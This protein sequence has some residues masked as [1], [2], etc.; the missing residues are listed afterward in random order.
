MRNIVVALL[1]ACALSILIGC[2][3]KTLSPEANKIEDFLIQEG[4]EV[5]SYKGEVLEYDLTQASMDTMPYK[6]YWALPGNDPQPIMGK[7][8]TVHKFIVK[9]HPLDHYK[10][11]NQQAKGKTEVYVYAA[12]G[13][14]VGGN[15]NPVM[16]LE[17]DG[18]YWSLHGET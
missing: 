18:G 1:I 9:N 10:N 8:V 2:T 7:H 14:I 3:D 15:S 13:E 17:Q 5:L 16:P 11:G 12:D 6:A 4:F